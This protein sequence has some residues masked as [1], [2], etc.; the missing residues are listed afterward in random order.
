MR[1][2][3]IAAIH[4]E[5]HFNVACLAGLQADG[6][7]HVCRDITFAAARSVNLCRQ[8]K[9]GRDDDQGNYKPRADECTH[10][11]CFALS[12]EESGEEGLEEAGAEGLFGVAAALAAPCASAA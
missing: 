10:L 2:H 1:I 3:V 12:L 5:A 7:H 4:T 8:L 6:R 9:E 11:H